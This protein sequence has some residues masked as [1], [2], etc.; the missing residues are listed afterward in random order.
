MGHLPVCWQHSG[1]ELELQSDG[2]SCFSSASLLALQTHWLGPC[3]LIKLW[4]EGEACDRFSISGNRTASVGESQLLEQFFNEVW[5]QFRQSCFQT[6]LSCRKCRRL[7]VWDSCHP[8]FLVSRQ[9]RKC[10]SLSLFLCV[11]LWLME[12]SHSHQETRTDHDG[13]CASILI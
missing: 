1:C 6:E 2:A 3:L 5:E 11:R 9:Q 12:V 13:K 4:C 8:V 10:Q 7:S